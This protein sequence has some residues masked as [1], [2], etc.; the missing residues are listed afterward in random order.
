MSRVELKLNNFNQFG[1]FLSR[2]KYIFK[3]ICNRDKNILKLKSI[4][5]IKLKGYFCSNKLW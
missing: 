3:F 4:D 2:E 1:V 5:E